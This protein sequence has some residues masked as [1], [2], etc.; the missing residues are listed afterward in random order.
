MK[1]DRDDRSL[2]QV[3]SVSIHAHTCTHHSLYQILQ[4]TFLFS[5]G[6]FPDSP[7]Y[8]DSKQRDVPH[9]SGS[10]PAGDVWILQASG[11]R[12]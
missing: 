10:G 6:S 2:W 9:F 11:S 4:A 3:Q 8:T 12:N 1:T 5:S 7:G